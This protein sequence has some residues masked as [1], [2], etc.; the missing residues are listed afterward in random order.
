M[1]TQPTTQTYIFGMADITFGDSKLPRL[2]DAAVLKIEPEFI[3]INSYELGTLADK[4]VKSYKVTVDVVFEEE[5]AEVMGLALPLTDGADSALGESLRA[6]GK[7]LKIHPRSA[8]D[9]T[10]FDLTIYKAVPSSGLERR[11]GLEQGKVAVTFEALVKDGAVAGK[12]DNIFKFGPKASLP[13]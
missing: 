6:K 13:A 5:T 9:K 10:D 2:A 8:G 3:D 4:L 1:P 12:P 11:Y 7:E